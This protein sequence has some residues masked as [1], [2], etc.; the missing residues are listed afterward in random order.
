MSTHTHTAHLNKHFVGFCVGSTWLV[1]DDIDAIESISH[2][3]CMRA[4]HALL[5]TNNL[6]SLSKYMCTHRTHTHP[7]LFTP[8]RITAFYAIKQQPLVPS[9]GSLKL[10]PKKCQ[11]VP[12]TQKG[13]RPLPP[14]PSLSSSPYTLPAHLCKVLKNRRKSKRKCNLV[15]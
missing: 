4:R 5:K 14:T 11:Q 10:N 12:G 3:F 7:R 2:S 15:L 1:I 8:I 6:H 13:I 9:G